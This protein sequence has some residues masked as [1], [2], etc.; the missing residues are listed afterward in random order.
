ME[1]MFTYSKQDNI[2][3]SLKESPDKYTYLIR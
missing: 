2:Y 3:N 1:K